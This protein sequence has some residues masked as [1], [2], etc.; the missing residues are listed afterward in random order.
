MVVR[1]IAGAMFKLREPDAGNLRWQEKGLANANLLT[2][3][4]IGAV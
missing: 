3:E 2:L 4:L 1:A